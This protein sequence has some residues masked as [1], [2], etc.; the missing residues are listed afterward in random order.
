MS[1]LDH[2]SGHR[3]SYERA[4]ALCQHSQLNGC[5]L[6]EHVGIMAETLLPASAP[7]LGEGRHSPEHRTSISTWTPVVYME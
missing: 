6:S 7:G 1:L 5:V 2:F 4:G 3:D